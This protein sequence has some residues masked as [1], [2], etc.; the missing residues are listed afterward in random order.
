MPRILHIETSGKSCSVAISKADSLTDF[1]TISEDKSHAR[2]LTL[3]IQRLLHHNELASE[4]LD[5]VA[6]SA[7]PGS[8]TGLRI[9]ISV[10]KAI[11]YASPLPLITV[12]S[13]EIMLEHLFTSYNKTSDFDLFVPMIDARR[14]EVY[15]TSYTSDGKRIADVSPLILDANAY[16]DQLEKHKML[17]FGNGAEKAQ[18]VI[19]HPHAFFIPDVMPDA[20]YMISGALH[21]YHHKNFEDVAYYEPF[22]LKAFQA[23]TPKKLLF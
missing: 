18:K 20:T 6:V 11:C 14:M 21:C 8:Y 7:G 10:A 17:F 1:D 2:H 13:M 22:Y 15:Q 9:G 12:P 4:D 23:T 19:T 3:M 5:A 16:R